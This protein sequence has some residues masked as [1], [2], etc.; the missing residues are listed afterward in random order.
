MC[1][2]AERPCHSPPAPPIDAIA[3]DTITR[4]LNFIVVIGILGCLSIILCTEF[5]TCLLECLPPDSDSDVCHTQE[6]SPPQTIDVSV[7]C[8]TQQPPESPPA[9]STVTHDDVDASS[10]PPS[11]V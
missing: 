11:C 2:N 9:Y 6:R 3:Q 7:T 10:L 1:D 5:F 4:T 8:E